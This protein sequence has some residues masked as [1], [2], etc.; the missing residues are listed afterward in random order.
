MGQCIGSTRF[1]SVIDFHC[2]SFFIV[3]I[4][5]GSTC[6]KILLIH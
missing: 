1:S 5:V 6:I 4:M 3:A 2:D